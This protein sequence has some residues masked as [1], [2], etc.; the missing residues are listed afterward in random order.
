MFALIFLEFPGSGNNI[1]MK[2]NLIKHSHF[3]ITD[4][5][6]WNKQIVMNV[7]IVK[8]KFEPSNKNYSVQ[9]V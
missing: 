3:Y 8:E 4:T 2:F 1:Q 6:R 5:E 9:D 7:L